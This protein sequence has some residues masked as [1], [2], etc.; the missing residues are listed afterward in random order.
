MSTFKHIDALRLQWNT[1][2]SRWFRN[3]SLNLWFTKYILD[4]PSGLVILCLITLIIAWGISAL[5]RK[6]RFAGSE[7]RVHRNVI[8]ILGCCNAGKTHLFYRLQGKDFQTITTVSSLKPNVFKFTAQSLPASS[9]LRSLDISSSSSVVEVV[10]FPGHTP[11]VPEL[12]RWLPRAMC[13]LFVIDA[14]D[15]SAI[16][17]SAEQL[18]SLFLRSE[19]SERQTPIVIVCN[20]TDL[21]ISKTKSGVQSDVLREI[22]RLRVSRTATLET[23]DEADHFLGVE[24]KLFTFDDAPVPVMVCSASVHTN[25]IDDVLALL[26]DAL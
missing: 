19:L 25:Q 6:I 12:T 3:V 4:F 14:T 11:L 9:P 16:K 17:L 26:S 13:V 2:L 22:E 18:Y 1:C 15:K 23:E 8:L 10:D 7:S 24:G 5:V 20:K 21:P